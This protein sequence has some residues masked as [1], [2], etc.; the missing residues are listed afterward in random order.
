MMRQDAYYLY[1][2]ILAHIYIDAWHYYILYIAA[3][4][5]DAQKYIL[6]SQHAEFDYCAMLQEEASY[7]A[8][9]TANYAWVYTAYDLVFLCYAIVFKKLLDARHFRL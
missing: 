5:R 6:F 4:L 3:M 8:F 9:M 1:I 2:D 7:I